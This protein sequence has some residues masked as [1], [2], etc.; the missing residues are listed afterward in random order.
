MRA[1]RTK[2]LYFSLVRPVAKVNAW[3]WRLKALEMEEP[4]WLNLGSGARPHPGFIN[5]EGGPFRKQDRW[6]DLRNKLP[7]RDGSVDAIYASHVLEHF[8][9]RELRKLLDECRRVLRP[10]GGVR[11]LVPSLT[12]GLVAYERGDAQWLG[13]WP[14]D[15]KSIGGRLSNYLLCEGQHR[16]IF[17]LSFMTEFLSNSG[18]ES[19]HQRSPWQGTAF[20]DSVLSRIESPGCDSVEAKSL[21]VEAFRPSTP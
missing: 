15:F 5:I 19:V 10:G 8:F 9:S 20:P 21:I 12:Q 7:F 14:E 11:I 4:I 1:Q 13:H 2:D 17:D 16:Q 18:F 3:R 6:L